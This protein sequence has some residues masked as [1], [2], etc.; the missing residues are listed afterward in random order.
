[1]HRGLWILLVLA[2]VGAGLTVWLTVDAR[3]YVYDAQIVGNR[4]LSHQ[5]IFEVSG[6][7]GLHILWARSG[8]IESRILEALPSLKSVAASCH[9]P[10]ECTIYVVE[11]RPRILWD[12]GPGTSGGLW[13][14]DEEGAVFPWVAPIPV[15]DDTTAAA[16]GSDS[17]D[18]ATAPGIHAGQ[19]KSLNDPSQR[20]AVIGPLPREGGHDQDHLDDQVR[21]ALNELWESGIEPPVEFQYSAELGLSFIDERGWRVIVGKGSGMARRLQVLDRLAADLQSR[22]VTPRFVDLRFPEVPYYVPATD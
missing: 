5:E 15:G 4:L 18:P 16:A 11:R 1:M 10:S 14:I 8:A 3:F 13:W 6:L 19:V 7:Q 20:W 12:E 9:L 21:V 2:I 22:G 17:T